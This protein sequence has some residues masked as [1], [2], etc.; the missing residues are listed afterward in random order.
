MKQKQTKPLNDESQYDNCYMCKV[1]LVEN[2]NKGVHMIN[3]KKGMHYVCED[4][5]EKIQN[6]PSGKTK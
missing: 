6:N 3:D 1:S 4:C 5:G 2:Y